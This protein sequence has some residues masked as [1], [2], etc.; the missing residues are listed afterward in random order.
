MQ[1]Y[2]WQFFV[3]AFAGRVNRFLYSTRWRRAAV[4]G[5]PGARRREALA[6][7][8]PMRFV[9]G[10]PLS[11]PIKEAKTAV[12]P[13]TLELLRPE[14]VTEVTVDPL[15][16]K[17]FVYRLDGDTYLLVSPPWNEEE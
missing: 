5:L 8:N 11:D 7:G 15:S 9:R 14:F 1:P 17:P 4:E 2:L 13:Q 12:Y 16:G 6:P 3:M 10:Q